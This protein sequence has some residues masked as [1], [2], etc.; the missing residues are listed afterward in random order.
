MSELLCCCVVYVRTCVRGGGMHFRTL[1][2]IEN[3]LMGWHII[4]TG[5]ID[6]VH[7]PEMA[8]GV[9]RLSEAAMLK[10]RPDK[11]A[12][13]NVE[14]S[15]AHVFYRGG[16]TFPPALLLLYGHKIEGDNAGE[17]LLS[18]FLHIYAL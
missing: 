2:M 17:I 1:Q 14:G 13:V 9:S 3:L 7:V 10:V 15:S 6:F 16:S 8:D 12:S 4:E 5:D 11:S 18:S